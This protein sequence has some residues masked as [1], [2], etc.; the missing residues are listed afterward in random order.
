MTWQRSVELL[1]M[2]ILGGLGT[3]YGPILGAIAFVLLEEA[4]SGLTE[5]WKLIFAPLLVLVV[6]EGKGG[7][8]GLVARLR[9]SCNG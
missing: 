7:L 3:L 1:A 6:L 5:H 4:L 8:V 9:G 2:V